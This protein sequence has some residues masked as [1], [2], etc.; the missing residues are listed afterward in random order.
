MIKRKPSMT[1]QQKTPLRRRLWKKFIDAVMT[2]MIRFLYRHRL[3]KLVG[4]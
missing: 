3:Q 4:G 1:T 2:P